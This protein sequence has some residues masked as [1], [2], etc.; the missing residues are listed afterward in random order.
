MDA[1][2]ATVP[3]RKPVVLVVEDEAPVMRFLRATLSVQGYRVVE[4]STGAQALVEASTR[5]PDLVLLDLALPDLD[6]V[7][8]TRRLR[9]WSKVPVMVIS[10]RGKEKDKIEALDAGADD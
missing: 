8:V 5:G 9:Q 7:E 2:G 1:E 6:G 10:A 4:S 3:A